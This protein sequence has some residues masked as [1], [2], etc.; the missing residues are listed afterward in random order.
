MLESALTTFLL[1][2]QLAAQSA[3][4]YHL[5]R[6]PVA[7]GAELVT[8]FG[9]VQE[10]GG[11]ATEIPLLSV[12][13]DTLGDSD[14]ENDR[15]RYVWILTSTRPTPLQRVTSAL[16]FAYFSPG[17][18]RHSD[19]V[20]KPALDLAAP[21]K[22]VWP[23]LVSDGVQVLRLDP[24]GVSVRS[25]TR[26]YRGNSSEY[27]QLQVSQT[28][29]V[30]T[31]LENQPQTPKVLSSAELQEI[32]SRLS[33]SNRAFG[34]LVRQENLPRFYDKQNTEREQ[35]RGHNWELL[36]QRAELNGLYFEPLALPDSTPS[37]AVLWLARGDL[38]RRDGRQ[39]TR[40]FLN[41][42]NPWTDDRLLNWTG[43]TQTRYFDSDDHPVP[44]GAPGAHPVEMIPLALYSLD[45]PHVPLLLVDFRNTSQPRRRE[46]V[47]HGAATVITGVL[48][49]SRF[50]NWPFL[51]ASSAWTFV[52]GRQ[53]NAVNRSARLEAYAGARAFL[54]MDSGIDPAFRSEL[55]QRLGHLAVNPLEN[56]TST[57]ATVAREQYAALSQYA[58]TPAGLPAKLQAERQRELDSY[59]RPRVARVLAGFGRLF[60]GGPRVG[61]EKSLELRAQLDSYRRYAAQLR[62]L[63]RLLAASPRPDV[64]WDP[65]QIRHSIEALSAEPR[66]D[67]RA[68]RVIAQ[69]FERSDDPELRIACL[70][71][72]GRLDVYEAR[73]ELWRL[74]QDPLT[75]DSWRTL[76]LLYLHGNAT[77]QTPPEAGLQSGAE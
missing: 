63:D 52:R 60:T 43:Y 42:A 16:S 19:R 74:S 76:C 72:L 38:E 39:F 68:P 10:S 44:A 51:A 71:A 50:G 53:G 33:L 12:L 36:R 34:G 61:P 37:E 66:K 9:R 56:A 14:P 35:T 58:M 3:P 25:S 30:L 26:S 67:S 70:R 55:M 1:G 27:R 59:T 8:V 57:E 23:N 48:G 45:H 65:D 2:A 75:A 22:T 54:A 41:I 5:E 18:Q 32:Y 62:F 73:N 47:R 49:I 46:L 31:A 28:L 11:Q 13:R 40:Q 24:M 21:A 4:T 6:E 20:P 64:N 15:L 7:G 69:M 77:A 29:S 17:S